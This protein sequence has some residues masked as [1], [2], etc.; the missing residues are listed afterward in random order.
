MI[1]LHKNY[2][3]FLDKI[4]DTNFLEVEPTFRKYWNE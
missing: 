1:K 4:R 3:N 2:I